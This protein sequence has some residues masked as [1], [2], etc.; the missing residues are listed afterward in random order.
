MNEL[1]FTDN[2]QLFEEHCANKS[3]K[4]ASGY[5]SFL[6]FHKA[7]LPIYLSGR[8]GREFLNEILQKRGTKFNDSEA[9]KPSS[10]PR[11]TV[12]LP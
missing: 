7:F 6:F 2:I 9:L 1:D 8:K 5:E 4:I 10:E 11:F 3:V 12:Y